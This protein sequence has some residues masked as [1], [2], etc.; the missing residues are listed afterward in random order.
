[1]RALYIALVL[2]AGF[3]AQARAAEIPSSKEASIRELI[4]LS[5][6]SNLATQM[7]GGI[8][9]VLFESLR[10]Q[11]PQIPDRVGTVISGE[12]TGYMRETMDKP[13]GLIAQIVP[14]YA[15]HFTEK[16]ILQ[17]VAFYKTPVGAKLIQVLPQTVQES[18]QAGQAWGEARMPE[19]VQRIQ[20]AL[21][22]EGLLPQKQ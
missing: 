19:M 8:T 1:M 6:G 7:A 11:N 4:V 18:M 20:A 2:C 15:R 21:A 14:I 17:L 9:K 3:L 10:K 5:G 13:E 12:I 16:E 22:R